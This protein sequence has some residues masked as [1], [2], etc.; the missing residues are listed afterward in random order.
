MILVAHE[1][2]A[3]VLVVFWPVANLSAKRSNRAQEDTQLPPHLFGSARRWSALQHY[4]PCMYSTYVDTRTQRG[5]CVLH[6]HRP[7]KHRLAA[8]SARF[9]LRIAS[10]VARKCIGGRLLYRDFYLICPSSLLLLSS[11]HHN[12]FTC[13]PAAGTT[14]IIRSGP[15]RR[16][17]I[18][19]QC[20]ACWAVGKKPH[21]IDSPQ[22]I[23]PMTP[24]FPS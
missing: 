4:Y 22:R 3:R 2:Y 21:P 6:V 24:C 15:H 12:L 16:L 18:G 9:L 20:V 19:S 1:A 5:G 10:L 17:Q 7:R 8:G 13:T 14:A 11:L 23:R